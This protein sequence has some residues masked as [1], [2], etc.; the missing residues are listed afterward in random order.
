MRFLARVVV[1]LGSLTA[2]SCASD[3]ASSSPTS[4]SPEET[5]GGTAGSTSLTLQGDSLTVAVP[6][7]WTT[8]EGT[9]YTIPGVPPIGPGAIV[10]SDPAA[11]STDWAVPGAFIAATTDLADLVGTTGL[12]R[13]GASGLGERL[14]ALAEWHGAIDR[15]S[16]CDRA[17]ASSFDSDDGTLTG[18]TTIWENCG[19]AGA[20]L[21]D[22]A[23]VS[24]DGSV[25]LV[26]QA[27]G[28]T[29]A[30]VAAAERVLETVMVDRDAVV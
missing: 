18:F 25:I 21:L 15:S 29:E 11:W 4:E 1:G 3:G 12:D 22:T 16:E 5:R 9:S 28:V 24:E 13:E 27:T 6:S 14:T 20:T 17:G 10:S 30:E 2:V 26:V 19:V 8:V 7:D 23:A